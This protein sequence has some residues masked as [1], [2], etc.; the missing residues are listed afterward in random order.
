MVHEGR[1][2][3]SIPEYPVISDNIR[4]VLDEVKYS[5]DPASWSMLFKIN[6]IY[7]SADISHEYP[8]YY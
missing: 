8:T 2:R 4:Q 1:S 6:V 5:H 3:P 7:S